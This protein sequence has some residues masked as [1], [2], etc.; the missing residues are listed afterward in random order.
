MT[1]HELEQQVA[2]KTGEEIRTIRRRGFGLLTEIQL[3]ER[4][5][6]FVIDWDR[7]AVSRFN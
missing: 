5:K 4:Q 7:V 2:D 6:P 1:Q 3:E